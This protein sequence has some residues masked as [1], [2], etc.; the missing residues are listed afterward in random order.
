MSSVSAVFVNRRT[1]IERVVELAERFGEEHQLPA[2]VVMSIHLVLDEVVANIISHGYDDTAEHQIHVTLALD[3][4]V[5]TIRVED[6]GRAFD[7]LAAPPPDLDLPLEERPVGGLG[8]H[9]VRSVMDAVEYQRDGDRN[10]LI[11]K[12][13]IGRSS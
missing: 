7:P 11:M 5:L 13:T 3:E 10:V 12:K 9:I 2:E 1:E 6:D 4:S 8:I